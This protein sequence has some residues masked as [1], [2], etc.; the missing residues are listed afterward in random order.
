MWSRRGPKQGQKVLVEKKSAMANTCRVSLF[1]EPSMHSCLG[2]D[3]DENF[4]AADIGKRFS[5]I[6]LR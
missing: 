2:L 4:G 3:G 6:V 5:H 1:K